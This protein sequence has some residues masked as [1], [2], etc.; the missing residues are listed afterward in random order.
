MMFK[1]FSFL[2]K[3]I[4]G[5]WVVNQAKKAG[6]LF[7]LRFLAVLRQSLM[8]LLF[9]L[10]AFQIIM[11]SLVGLVVTGVYLAPIETEM[12]AWVLFGI[13]CFTLIVAAVLLAYAFSEKTWLKY[14]GANDMI[15]KLE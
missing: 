2:L 11:F 8:G 5:R 3:F 10:V 9:I 13:C 12:K 14:S 15:A 6:V 1:I 4:E 7:Y